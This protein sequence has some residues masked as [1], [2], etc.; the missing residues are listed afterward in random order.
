MPLLLLL[1]VLSTDVLAP[2][3]TGLTGD[4]SGDL[5]VELVTD[6]DGTAVEMDRVSLTA[7][8]GAMGFSAISTILIVFTD[9]VPLPPLLLRRFLR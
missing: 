1:L 9:G 8:G 4:L 3:A 2:S 6:L 5:S 7:R